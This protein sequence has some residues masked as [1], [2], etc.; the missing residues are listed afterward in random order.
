M[1]AEKE[2]FDP[3]FRAIMDSIPEEGNPVLQI[4]NFNK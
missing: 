2:Q 1:Q 4:M 3:R